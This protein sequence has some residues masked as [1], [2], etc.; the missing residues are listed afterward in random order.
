MASPAQHI[1]PVTTPMKL[2]AQHTAA[3]T[4]PSLRKMRQAKTML[5]EGLITQEDYDS[6]KSSVLS[7][8][9]SQTQENPSDDPA[10]PN[11]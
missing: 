10:V 9:V 5:E 2:A 4:P 11:F 8:I 7:S 6:M 1:T 3:A